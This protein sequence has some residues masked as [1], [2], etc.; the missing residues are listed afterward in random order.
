MKNQLFY[1]DN[2]DVLRRYIADES[3]DLVYLDPPFNSQQ[4]YN[5]LFKERSGKQASAQLH[6]FEDTWHWDEQAA[7]LYQ[8]TVETGGR[9]SDVLRAF[10]T[11]LDENDLMAYLVMMAPRLVELRRVLKQT[12]SLYL[13]C[14]PT[15][16]HYLKVL[17]DAVFGAVNFKNEIIWKRTSSQNSAK[18]FG[19]VHDTL[20]FYSRSDDY[21]WNSLSLPHSN[22]YAARFRRLDEKGRAYSDDNLTAP[23]VRHGDSGAVWRGY[24]P[25]ARGVHWKANSATVAALVGQEQAQRMTTT[26]KLDLMDEHGSILWSKKAAEDGGGFPR[27]KRFLSGGAPVQDVIT[28]IFPINSQAQER[29]GYPTQKPEALLE[30]ILNASSNEG[31]VVLD[32]FCGCGTTVAVAQQLKR[33]WIG[34]DI[35]HL[36]IGLIKFRLA[37]S[38]GDEVASTYEVIGE[39]TTLDDARQLAEEDKFQF[40]NWA[41]GLVGARPAGGVK[42]GADRGVDGKSI[43]HDGLGNTQEI[44]YSVKGGNL[45]ATDVRD[46]KGVVQREKAV[47]GVLISFEVPSKEMR[48]EAATGEFYI[49]EWGTYPMWQLLTIED[50]LNGKTVKRPPVRQVDATFKKAPKAKSAAGKQGT[51]LE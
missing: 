6:A 26:E 1:G 40:Q 17:L 42:K 35:T 32:P 20:L 13:H 44:I 27:F 41:L 7:A 50:L 4:N 11:F 31:D 39:P 24:D 10:R 15:A 30:R 37:H 9:V 18:R 22:E 36:A 2:L 16:S 14:D 21:C 5:V 46:L 19:P 45:K 33:R 43:F 48:K 49:C 8:A 3:V 25:T 47:I 23:G 38:Y 12:G 29:L 28:D 51:L 34:I